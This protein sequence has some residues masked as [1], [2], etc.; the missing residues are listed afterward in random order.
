MIYFRWRIPPAV[1]GELRRADRVT[2]GW[3]GWRTPRYC[4]RARHAARCTS[5]GDLGRAATGRPA[6]DSCGSAATPARGAVAR[7]RSRRA[8]ERGR[9]GWR[10]LP[11]LPRRGGR[12]RRPAHVGLRV[13]GPVWVVARNVPDRDGGGRATAAA[14]GVYVRAL[15]VLSYVQAAAHRPGAAASR[16]RAVGQVR[17]RGG[18]GQRAP[19]G[20]DH[21]RRARRGTQGCR[22]R[23]PKARRHGR[24]DP[25][26]AA[27]CTPPRTWLSLF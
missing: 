22:G 12:R 18:D 24:W 25:S 8:H 27:R 16:G 11:G 1:P 5:S 26:T 14:V 6:R 10:V 2:L 21:V 13:P 7:V 17:A 23:A 15:G 20:G 9:A 19:R 4:S 3:A